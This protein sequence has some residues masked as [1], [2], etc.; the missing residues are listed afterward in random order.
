MFSFFNV[1]L[2]VRFNYLVRV[3]F[4]PFSSYAE[5]IAFREST[6]LF[7]AEISIILGAYVRALSRRLSCP[8]IVWSLFF[9]MTASSP[10]SS[11]PPWSSLLASCSS[12]FTPFAP[13]AGTASKN[14]A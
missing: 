3:D 2:A 10:S 7:A 6:L 14:V 1:R 12:L 4:P 8:S 5:Y 11:L 13:D 9:S